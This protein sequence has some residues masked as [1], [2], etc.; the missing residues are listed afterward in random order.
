MSTPAKIDGIDGAKIETQ[1]NKLVANAKRTTVFVGS[2]SLIDKAGTITVSADVVTRIGQA[3]QKRCPET[4]LLLVSAGPVGCRIYA[5]TPKDTFSALDWFIACNPS[6][7]EHGDERSAGGTLACPLSTSGCNES[8]S[9][10]KERDQIMARAFAHLRANSLLSDDED[11][12]EK[13]PTD[14]FDFNA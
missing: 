12:N 9:A 3:V 11:S 10:F 8:T 2:L 1:I 14:Y 13:C 5:T 6:D 7:G 4:A